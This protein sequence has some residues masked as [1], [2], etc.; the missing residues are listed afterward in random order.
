[1][2]RGGRPGTR[3]AGGRAGGEVGADEDG[4]VRTAIVRDRVDGVP[5]WSVTCSATLCEPAV[6]ECVTSGPTASSKAP[7][8]SRSQFWLLRD[9]SES[10]EYETNVTCSPA[11]GSVGKLVKAPLAVR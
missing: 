1:V 3:A 7:S 4:G 11:S 9:P 6:K 5:S 10:C 8:A 2:R